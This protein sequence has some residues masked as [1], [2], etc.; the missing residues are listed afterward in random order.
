M[1]FK[2]L[3][4]G[5]LTLDLELGGGDVLLAVHLPAS[6]PQGADPRYYQDALFE[7]AAVPLPAPES[8]QQEAFWRELSAIPVGS[9]C[10][11]G[12]L[13][14]ALNTAPRGVASRCASNRLLLRLPC[15]R[16]VGKRGMGGFRAG[17]AWKRRLLDWERRLAGSPAHFGCSTLRNTGM[18]EE[19]PEFVY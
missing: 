8:I 3:R 18:I 17:L 2:S 6:P 14:K 9:T 1:R 10:A 16:V 19:C 12:E 13:A 15:H 7:L 11:Y 5:P 4:F